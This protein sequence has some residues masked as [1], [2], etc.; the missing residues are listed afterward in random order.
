[1]DSELKTSN[2]DAKS[3]EYQ[4]QTDETNK[5]SSPPLNEPQV[6]DPAEAA[7]RK[8]SKQCSLCH[9][10]RDVLI[11]CQIDD[12]GTWHFICTGKCWKEVSGGV[13][14]GDGTNEWYKY[15]GMWKNK[16]E[17][18]SAKI[19]G[20]AKKKNKEKAR[21]ELKS[22]TKQ[23]KK[24]KSKERKEYGEGEEVEEGEESDDG[25]DGDDD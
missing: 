24:K 20:S 9:T 18:V 10:P 13:V 5:T 25:T 14:D 6:D 8:G 22:A 16:H 1:M 4:H 11:R 12:T 2:H 7:P 21:D 23:R 3:V 17:G 19:K 15:G